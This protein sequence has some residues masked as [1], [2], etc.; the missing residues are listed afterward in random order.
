MKRFVDM[1]SAEIEG[2]RFAF[3]CTVASSFVQVDGE[4]GWD[5]KADFMESA[6]GYPAVDIDRL[7]R[8]M[9]DWT[10]EAP[11]DGT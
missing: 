1:R 11:D 4:M 8:L 7:V 9:P 5:T 6:G 3:W 10:E 2:H